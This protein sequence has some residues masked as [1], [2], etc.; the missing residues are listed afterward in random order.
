MRTDGQILVVGPDIPKAKK[1][2]NEGVF[3]F[4]WGHTLDSLK[5]GG[6]RWLGDTHHWE[7]D[8]AQVIEM[9]NTAGW[10]LAIDLHNI[11][12]VTDFWP[13][14]DRAPKWQCAVWG[15]MR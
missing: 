12:N 7:C 9:L 15:E 11:D 8:A 1:M 4:R 10:S 14:A 6:D 13:V 5:H 3:D 2:I